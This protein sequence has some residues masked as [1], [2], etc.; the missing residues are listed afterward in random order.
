VIQIPHVNDRAIQNALNVVKDYLQRV[1]R[2]EIVPVTAN[3]TADT[4]FIVAHSLGA[5]PK[6]FTWQAEIE[7]M[8]YATSED[9]K[10]WGANQIKVRC[11]V[12]N[13]ALLVKVEA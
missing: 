1:S 3:A 10:E 4:P 8:C 13:A 11:T 7:A 5:T 2:S 9:K 12:A 6:M